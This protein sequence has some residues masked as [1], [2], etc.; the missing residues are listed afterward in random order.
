MC[1]VCDMT[2]TLLVS[3]NVLVPADQR[4][5]P[6]Q[7]AVALAA[8]SGRSLPHGLSFLAAPPEAQLVPPGRKS[9]SKTV[10]KAHPC[11]MT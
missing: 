9:K 4:V 10:S 1:V 7:P 8:A 2:G 5:C 6:A 3:V 11:Q